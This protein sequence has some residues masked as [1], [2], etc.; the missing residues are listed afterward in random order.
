VPACGWARS[1][2]A[3]VVSE[4]SLGTANGSPRVQAFEAESR[5]YLR[6]GEAVLVASGVDPQSGEVVEAEVTIETAR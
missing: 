6:E 5:L 3:T 2:S 4:G 1:A